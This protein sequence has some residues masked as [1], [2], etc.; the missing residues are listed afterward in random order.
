MSL[1]DRL[2]LR[3]NGTACGLVTKAGSAR[4]Q[5]L[6][7]RMVTSVVAGVL[8][9][10]A[11]PSMAQQSLERVEEIWGDSGPLNQSLRQL[12]FEMRRPSGF[13]HLYRVPGSKNLLTRMDGSLA[14]V[15]PRS[16][17]SSSPNGVVPLIPPGTVFYV[18]SLPE[19]SRHQW[20]TKPVVGGSNLRTAGRSSLAGQPSSASM[21]KPRPKTWPINRSLAVRTPVV[22]IDPA[23]VLSSRASEPLPDQSKRTI[24]SDEFY[25]R[26]RLKQL[27]GVVSIREELRLR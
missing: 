2:H 5:G 16:V 12:P 14:A 18:G 9:V 25:R 8:C 26:N 27:L 1:R 22:R 15:F 6:V 17:Y 19:E 23:R 11:S 21:F 20:G 13:E 4:A 24:W 10:A 3:L 7:A